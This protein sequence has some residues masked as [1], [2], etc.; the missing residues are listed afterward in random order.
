VSSVKRRPTSWG[1]YLTR[2]RRILNHYFFTQAARY[3]VARAVCDRLYV[4]LEEAKGKAAPRL[5][6]G[7]T[8]K[9]KKRLKKQKQGLLPAA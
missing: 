1:Q 6:K 2:V 5:G 3:D 4:K 9:Q 8:K 7:V